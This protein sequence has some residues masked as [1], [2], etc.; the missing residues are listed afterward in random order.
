MLKL[1]KEN[2]KI[3]IESYS[4][5]LAS[6]GVLFALAG[7]LAILF[8]K[9]END[10][11]LIDHVIYFSVCF[12]SIAIHSFKKIEVN[13]N[14]LI[15]TS[16][17]LLGTKTQVLKR[18]EIATVDMAYGKGSYARG[19]SIRLDTKNEESYVLVA[20]DLGQRKN[21]E[22]LLEDVKPFL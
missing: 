2:G 15:I 5:R 18:S 8:G 6:I 22:R 14:D 10:L 1:E 21:I 11:Q 7:L 4:I 16:R 20:Y 13:D 3:T 19:G 9:T 12:I 17:S